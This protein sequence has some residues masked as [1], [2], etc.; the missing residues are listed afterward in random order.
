[1]GAP[2]W[3]EFAFATTS[4][5]RVRMV[6]GLERCVL[7]GLAGLLPRR[8]CY[9]LDGKLVSLGERRNRHDLG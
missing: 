1:M 6:L 9:V 4:A 5:A 2:G 3:P 8:G 7:A